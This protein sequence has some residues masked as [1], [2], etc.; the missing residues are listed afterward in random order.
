LRMLR[1]WMARSM[2]DGYSELGS[3]D[4][5]IA[6]LSK[7]LADH[8][9]G[10]VTSDDLVKSIQVNELDGSRTCLFSSQ[11]A[12]TCRVGAS[13]GAATVAFACD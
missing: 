3:G 5:L 4:S 12:K 10:S 7:Y 6:A 11:L 9:F 1:A 13:R 2:G 8:A